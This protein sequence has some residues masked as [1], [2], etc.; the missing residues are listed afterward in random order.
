MLLYGLEHTVQTCKSISAY[1]K[2]DRK[3]RA[4]KLSTR[5][6][7]IDLVRPLSPSKG[8][9]TVLPVWIGSPNG[10][11]HF[12]RRREASHKSIPSGRKR[13]SG[14]VS[15]SVE[16]GYNGAWQRSVD[17]SIAHHTFEVSCYLEGGSTS[18]NHGNDLWSSHKDPWRISMSI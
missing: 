9:V 13:P 15:S 11:K 10:Q 8:F 14:E 1:K 3:I 12:H 5:A 18:H 16:S 17:R 4:P 6:G 7:H 2:Q